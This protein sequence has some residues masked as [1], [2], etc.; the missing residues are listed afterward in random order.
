MAEHPVR[1][2]AGHDHRGARQRP[3]RPEQAQELGCFNDERQ[4]VQRLRRG[5][6]G[7]RQPAVAR[8]PELRYAGRERHCQRLLSGALGG[9]KCCGAD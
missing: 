5:P 8:P 2:Q 6:A 7:E 4:G 9:G 3:G 1:L